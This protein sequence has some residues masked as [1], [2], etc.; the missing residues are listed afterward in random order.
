MSNRPV[1]ELSL[2]ERR[3]RIA[4]LLGIG[5]RR[6]LEQKRK[7][8]LNSGGICLDVSSDP[9]LSVSQPDGFVESDHGDED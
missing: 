1:S 5:V 2:D 8:S 4:T 6:V 9:R 7:N 3:E